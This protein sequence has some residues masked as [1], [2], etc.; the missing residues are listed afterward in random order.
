MTKSTFRFTTA[1]EAWESQWKERTSR[2]L[3]SLR[4]RPKDLE[5]PLSLEIGLSEFRSWL[6]RQAERQGAL[7][8]WV[9]H[10]CGK[11]IDIDD[12]RV[13]HDIPLKLGGDPGP[14]NW[15]ISCDSCNRAKGAIGGDQ[16]KGL[17]EHI[18]PWPQPMKGDLYGRL[19]GLD[20]R[21]TAWSRRRK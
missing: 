11:R 19:K 5:L 3:G 1:T 14:S 13:D 10:Y 12:V 20:M 8:V 21:K 17:I 15:K 7:A 4:R 6:M 9:C 18:R 16:F 2:M